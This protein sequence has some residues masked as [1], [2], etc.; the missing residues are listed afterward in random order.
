MRTPYLDALR[1]VLVIWKKDFIMEETEKTVH[2]DFKI[3][4]MI[5]NQCL[6]NRSKQGLF[7][8]LLKTFLEILLCLVTLVPAV[9][10]IE[11]GKPILTTFLIGTLLLFFIA[12]V[13]NNMLD[14]GLA[15]VFARLVEKSFVT[16]GFLFNGF[17]D[18]TGRVFRASVFL[19]VLDVLIYVLV[20]VGVYFL[21]PEIELSLSN[22]QTAKILLLSF[23]VVSIIGL[24]VHFI[25]SFSWIILYRDEKC[26]ALKAFGKS[27]SC[28]FR[29]FF[30]YLGFYFYSGG[31]DL[32]SFILISFVLFFIPSDANGILSLL[33]LVLSFAQMVEQFKCLVRMNFATPIYFYSISGVIQIHKSDYV[34]PQETIDSPSTDG[35]A[36]S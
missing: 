31:R 27:I 15:V 34:P 21:F 6:M 26:G 32:V 23:S 36:S 25:F 12:S 33:A 13:V 8:L 17:R 3:M 19:T 5:L 35:T 18:K 1:R 7:T 10:L 29:H 20:G 16:M 28:I 4:R 9:S 11:S 22:K 14:Y 2:P 24:I 30:H